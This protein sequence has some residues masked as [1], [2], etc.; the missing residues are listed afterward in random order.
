MTLTP[1]SVL[2]EMSQWSVQPTNVGAAYSLDTYREHVREHGEAA[3]FKGGQPAHVTSSILVLSTDLTE[4]LLTFHKKA[5][6]WLQF[7]GH[8]ERSDRSLAAAAWR[9][10]L[11]ESGLD[12]FTAFSYEPS[13][14]DI[15]ALGG[16]FDALCREHWD[17]AFVA[18][19]N[20]DSAVVVS[21]ESH[22]VRWFPVDEL[23]DAGA[24]DMYPRVRAAIAHARSQF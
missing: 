5:N 4:V 3:L 21:D 23:P 17:I 15:H 9:E 24:G 8:L 6:M 13:D 22:D 1:E 16:G 18:L 2:A 12:T 7:G 20:R 11:E 14:I 19:A 10:G